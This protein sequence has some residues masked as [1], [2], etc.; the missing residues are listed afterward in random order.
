[1]PK[2]ITYASY[3]T[4]G[5]QG[6]LKKPEDRAAAIQNLLDKVGA[7]IVALYMT[8]GSNDIVLVTD[9]AD[10]SDVAALSLAVS[11]SGSLSRCETVRAWTSDEFVVVAEKAASISG[12]YVPPGG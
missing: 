2:F 10:G 6:L 3:S 9:A 11:A 5:M 4:S 12:I 1:M 7:K 8:T